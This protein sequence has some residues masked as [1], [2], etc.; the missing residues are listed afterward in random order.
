MSADWTTRP[1]LAVDTEA[2]PM[3][4][5]IDAAGVAP[6]PGDPVHLALSAEG[7]ALV[8]GEAG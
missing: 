4:V 5:T 2:G 6:A 7:S 3:F 1:V 8:R